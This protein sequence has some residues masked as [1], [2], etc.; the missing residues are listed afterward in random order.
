MEESAE[1]FNRTQPLQSEGRPPSEIA[2]AES[3]KRPEHSRPLLPFRSRSLSTWAEDLVFQAAFWMFGGGA[4]VTLCLLLA[5]W[6]W[7]LLMRSYDE[8]REA[9]S[10]N[11][12]R[13]A[14]R[15]GSRIHHDGIETPRR[16]SLHPDAA[17]HSIYSDTATPAPV[18][19]FA[20]MYQQAKTVG[21][22]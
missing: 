3:T 9:I 16:L 15:V 22:T 13:L 4:V 20:G 14:S 19:P 1:A 7:S 11:V 2:K 18:L 6:L 12:S 5:E 8:H 21:L 10:R 17:T